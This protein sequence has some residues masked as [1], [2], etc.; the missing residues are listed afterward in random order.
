MIW[1]TDS[2]RGHARVDY[3]KIALT[4]LGVFVTFTVGANHDTLVIL[5]MM[6]CMDYAT[7]LLAAVSLRRVNSSTG[8]RGIAKKIGLLF[9]VSLGHMTDR[10]L[11]LNDLVLNVC[12]VFIF[13]NE[14]ISIVE[15]L[16][17]MGVPVPAKLTN[18]LEQLR[19]KDTE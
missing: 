8:L 9:L 16:A 5:L 15:N 2:C 4:G 17:L 6:V 19:E 10:I 11:G 3:A 18:V 12:I 7:G 1:A 13:A 14:G